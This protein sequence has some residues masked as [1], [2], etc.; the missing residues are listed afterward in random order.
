VNLPHL[1][2]R[3]TE[4]LGRPYDIYE[5]LPTFVQAVRDLGAQTVIE[6]GVRAGVST[7]AWLYA[8]EQQG[9][10]HLWSV[11]GAH[12]V[13]DEFGN[14]LLGDLF[15]HPQWTFIEM[16]DNDPDLSPLLPDS[17]DILFVDAQHTYEET[18]FELE[19]FMPHVRSGGRAYFHDTALLETANAVTSQPPY[20]VR[21]AI[22]DYC[23]KHP[24]LRFENVTNCNGLGTVYVP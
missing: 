6:L 15:G 9:T 7:V 12:P 13:A 22:E 10:G 4:V 8:L 20:P 14:D 17:I 18:S 11:D 19:H 5:H 2:T 3:F 16:W 21:S 24:D 1:P 23:A